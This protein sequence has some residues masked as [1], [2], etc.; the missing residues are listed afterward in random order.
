MVIQHHIRNFSWLFS[1]H[2]SAT[3]IF[4]CI[5][6]CIGWIALI[7]GIST[8]LERSLVE[9]GIPIMLIVIFAWLCAHLFDRMAVAVKQELR[10][11]IG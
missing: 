3:T 10:V 11:D 7:P 5:S 2:V 6:Y 1:R 4:A 9:R 8:D